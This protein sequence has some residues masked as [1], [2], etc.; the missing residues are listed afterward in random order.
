MKTMKLIGMMLMAMLMTF[1]LTACGDDDN[2]KGDT[3]DY[4]GIWVDT[5]TD[6]KMS[7]ITLKTNSY[8]NDMYRKDNNTGKATKQTVS[9]AMSVSGNSISI[10]GE[11]P[12]SKATYSIS[13][14]KMTI[15]PEGSEGDRIVLTRATEDHI[16]RIAAWETL[17]LASNF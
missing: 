17:V 16:K 3:A 1:N 9:G 8:Q 12:F 14:N 5:D 6:Q 10:N 13:G 15:V 4:V 7:V 2:K 11:A